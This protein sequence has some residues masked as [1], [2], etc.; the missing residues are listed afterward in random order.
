MVITARGK[1]IGTKQF[2]LS[3]ND[4][5]RAVQQFNPVQHP[6]IMIHR[7]LLPKGM[8]L[9]DHLDGAEDLQLLFKVFPYGEV[10]NMPEYLHSYRIHGENV[11]LK[12]IKSIFRQTLI[13]RYR[14][15]TRFGYKPTIWG[16]FI[17]FIQSLIVGALPERLIKLMYMK[18][19]G[20]P[21]DMQ[22][23]MNVKPA[24]RLSH[25]I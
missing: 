24:V 5:Y 14:G 25:S 10:H 20:V 4:I 1:K 11:S 18:T 7:R 9:Y 16:V 21:N 3:H 2:P 23:S 22:K 17:T 15:V 13:A 12:H 6:T 8:K 19:R